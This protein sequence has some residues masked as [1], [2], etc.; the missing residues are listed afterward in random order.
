M[1]LVHQL[2]QILLMRELLGQIVRRPKISE[3][4]VIVGLVGK[5]AKELINLQISRGILNSP[6]AIVVCVCVC[7]CL[8]VCVSVCLSVVV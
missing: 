7:V 4:R 1:M 2:Y 5:V 8:C 6:Y 3:T